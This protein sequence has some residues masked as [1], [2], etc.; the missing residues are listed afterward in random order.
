MTR[1]AWL[2]ARFIRFFY[3]ASRVREIDLLQQKL[4]RIDDQIV[5]LLAER[6]SVARWL[7]ETKAVYGLPAVSLERR[8]H[9]V[10][11]AEYR[12]I[13]RGIPQGLVRA[14]FGQVVDATAQTVG[15]P[16]E[17]DEEPLALAFGG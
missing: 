6:F 11:R 1:V 9:E 10:T 12:A 2:V 8:G 15:V 4:D 3:G 7:G 5:D 17:L 13:E 14:L 16:D